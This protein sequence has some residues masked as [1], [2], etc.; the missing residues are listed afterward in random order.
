MIA[1]LSTAVLCVLVF[2]LSLRRPQWGLLLIA[3]LVP[4]HGVLFIAPVLATFWKEAA[5]CTVVAACFFAPLP[6]GR[7]GVV[8]WLAPAVLL[9][10]FGTVSAV[11][12]LGPAAGFPV[13]IAFF[14]LLPVVVVHYFPFTRADKD[15]LVTLLLAT[16]VVS[17]G[18]GLW[19]QLAGGWALADLGYEW[20]EH[21]R[22]AGPLLRSFG[23]F[24][25]PFPF[26]FFLMLVLVVGGAAAL[27]EPGRRRSRLF[28]WLAP[29]LLVAMAS[30]V[31][32]A[33]IV[34][35][36][37]A[38]IVLGVVFHR[39][40]LGYLAA[41]L[42]LGVLAV[43]VA[44]ALDRNGA[45]ATML[46]STSLAERGGHWS[47][48]LPQLLVHPFGNGL[49]TTGS[50]AQR[51]DALSSSLSRLY[52]PDN[53]YL[54]IGLELGGV[55][56]ALYVVVV[57]IAVVVLY[58]LI[59]LQPDR[60]EQA[61]TAAALAVTLA[62]CVAGIFATY[63]EIFPLDFY[64]W[65]LLAVGASV[66]SPV[67][68]RLGGWRLPQPPVPRRARGAP[69]GAAG[70]EDTGDTASSRS[71]HRGAVPASAPVSSPPQTGT[72]EKDT[73]DER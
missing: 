7:A 66:P 28:W 20:N 73:V 61:V 36:L 51:V 57:G 32:R 52:Q 63:L 6:R 16:G 50:A 18:Y 53:Q 11:L 27:A 37:T 58:R 71:Q 38:V 67:A 56:L 12:V 29:V 62:A 68:A 45:L 70:A 13:K 35:L 48:T 8:P 43:P 30:S 72:T 23:T 5:V 39:R 2:V 1:L 9:V 4:F 15:R 31:V 24:N 34:G 60:F 40:L 10:I 59:R 21:I 33:S 42:G 65:L 14:Y 55:G 26:G 64:F 47:Q 25:Q 3:A 41:L 17:A 22:S 44:L 19:Q 54:K 49:G 69:G 46:S